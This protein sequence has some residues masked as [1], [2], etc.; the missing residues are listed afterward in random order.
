MIEQTAHV[1]GTVRVHAPAHAGQ[2]IG[3]RGSD[4]AA[5]VSACSPAGRG[6]TPA[7]LGVDGSARA[8]GARCTRAHAWRSSARETRWSQPGHPLAPGQIYDVNTATLAAVVREHGGHPGA[9]PARGGRSRGHR[10]GVRCRRSPKT[11]CSSRAAARLASAT[12]SSRRSRRAA[13]CGSRALRSSRA[14]RTIFGVVDG[15]PVFGMPGNPTSCLS[16]AYLLVAPLLRR[17]ARLPPPPD[18]V[19]ARAA[20]EDGELTG[21][22]TP[23]LPRPPR[24]RRGRAGVQ[25]I[26][27]HHEPAPAPMGTSRAQGRWWK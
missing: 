11:W 17:I 26:R 14:S 18:S 20:L 1:D 23:V 27:R 5:P 2:N 21:G 19:D 8:D 9:L 10:G 3:S 6:F 22:T 12:T 24:G 13:T 15:R 16:N 25:G 4:R 7:R